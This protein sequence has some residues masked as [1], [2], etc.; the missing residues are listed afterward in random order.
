MTPYHFLVLVWKLYHA[1]AS[2]REERLIHRKRYYYG[3]PGI[4]NVFHIINSRSDAKSFHNFLH[5]SIVISK[6]IRLV[7][8]VL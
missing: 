7:E 1:I 8:G 3:V 6:V 2:G 5:R 4:K